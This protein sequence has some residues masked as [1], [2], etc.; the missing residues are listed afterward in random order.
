MLEFL[1]WYAVVW[2]GFVA[3]IAFIL[4]N[5]TGKNFEPIFNAMYTNKE[6]GILFLVYDDDL[7]LFEK[8]LALLLTPFIMFYVIVSDCGRVENEEHVN[9][10]LGE[11]D[12]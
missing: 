8:F 4:S 7:N 10:L 9:S 1:F 2:N 5:S 12:V 11:D 3:A 6:Y